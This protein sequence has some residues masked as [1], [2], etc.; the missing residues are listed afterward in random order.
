MTWEEIKN[1]PKSGIKNGPW[2]GIKNGPWQGIGN[3]PWR[4]LQNLSGLA[5]MVKTRHQF[6]LAWI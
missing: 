1:V 6:D 5:W 3:G 4:E 2:R